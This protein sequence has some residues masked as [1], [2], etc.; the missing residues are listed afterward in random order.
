M[1]VTKDVLVIGGTGLVG[2]ELL[3]LLPAHVGGRIR[4]L[5]RR[6]GSVR[7]PGIDEQVVDFDRPADWMTPELLACEVFYVC[8]GTTIR[9]AG[10][11]EEFRRV[12]LELPASFFEAF[13]CHGL[14]PMVALVSSVGA[15][16]PTGF[17]LKSKAELE[18]RLVASGLPHRIL[19]PSLLL[20]DRAERRPGEIV[21]SALMRPIFGVLN[22]MCGRKAAWV[23]KYHPIE[24]RRVAR[25]LIHHTLVS[26]GPAS[27]RV[28][29]GWDLFVDP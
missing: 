3:S 27:G 22:V 28:V 13:R 2:K 12:D 11:V 1:K 8:L 4:A 23:G 14:A 25:A 9:K 19:R 18:S 29:E 26:P 6:T 15:D 24:A 10:S 17:Y 7:A 20:G 16:R 21:G 5:V